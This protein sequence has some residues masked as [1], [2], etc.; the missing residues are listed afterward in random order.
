[1]WLITTAG[2]FSIVAKPGD[3]AEGMLTVRA[4][5]APDLDKLRERYL[6]E[7][8]P[9]TKGGSDYPFRARAPVAAVASAAAAAVKDID[10]E[11]F[12]GRVEQH[13]PERAHLYL[14][15]WSILRRI[16]RGSSRAR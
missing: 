10:Y 5:A 14:D 15:V 2:F 7:L 8:G 11:N 1:M 4:R 3:A 9:T 6:P 13:A 12:K 16:T